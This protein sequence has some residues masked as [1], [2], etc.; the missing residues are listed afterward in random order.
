MM[1][2]KGILLLFL[3]LMFLGCQ[4]GQVSSAHGFSY[5]GTIRAGQW[6]R[7][8]VPLKTENETLSVAAQI[9]FPEGYISGSSPRTVIAFHGYNGNERHWERN[10]AIEKYADTYGFAIVCPDMGRSI[11][12]TRYYPETTN[13]WSPKP[14][15][16]FILE[17]LLPFLQRKLNLAWKGKST[18]IMGLSTG[19]RGALMCA[20]LQPEMFGGAAGL[21]GD[22]DPLAMKNNRL[23]TAVYGKY[24]DFPERWKNDDNIIVQAEKLKDTPVFLAHGKKDLVVPSEQSL[25]LAIR[26]K[27]LHRQNGGGY[28]LEFHEGKYRKHEWLFWNEQT[29]VMMAFFD[30]VLEK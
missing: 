5:E 11:F 27:S 16:L 12:A 15:A 3:P 1:F 14:G 2:K 22:Y 7:F 26:L 17:D 28:E 21:S 30:R 4:T 9:Y 18:G 8:S 6:N 20:T 24:R 13:K 10:S 23:L 19:G 25:L 29:P